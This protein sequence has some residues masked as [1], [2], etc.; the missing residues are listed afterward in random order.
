MS[1]NEIEQT[2]EL[3]ER[4]KKMLV[5]L[6]TVEPLSK[7]LIPC[8]NHLLNLSSFSSVGIQDGILSLLEN[9]ILIPK[10]ELNF[11]IVFHYLNPQLSSILHSLHS[12]IITTT[13]NSS[14]NSR[15]QSR[16]NFILLFLILL[17]FKN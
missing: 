10:E 8:L 1:D 2:N 6:L 12:F 7:K 9:L 11:N 4:K 14:M 5:L 17:S 3:N 16:Y 13:V 15:L